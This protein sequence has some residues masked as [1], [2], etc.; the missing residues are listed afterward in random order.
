M[1]IIIYNYQ[2][3]SAVLCS[4]YAVLM[5]CFKSRVAQHPNM[6]ADKTRLCNRIELWMWLKPY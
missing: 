1:S 4:F 2:A 3:C 5:R 6:D